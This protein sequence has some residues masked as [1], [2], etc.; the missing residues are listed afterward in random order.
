MSDKLFLLQSQKKS[1]SHVLHL[2]LSVITGGLW[3]I[4]WF[5]VAMSNKSHNNR[6]QG[7]MNRF[8]SYKA[9]GMSDVEAYQHEAKEIAENKKLKLRAFMVIAALVF[10]LY[11]INHQ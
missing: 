3:L 9:Q 7:D 2:I 1:T 11:M 8:F 6:I 5:C 4:V 10:I